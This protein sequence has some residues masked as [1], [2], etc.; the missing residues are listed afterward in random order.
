MCSFS[1]QEGSNDYPFRININ[2]AFGRRFS[3]TYTDCLPS[4][5]CRRLHHFSVYWLRPV[6]VPLVVAFFVVS[7]ITPVLSVLEKRLGVTRIVAAGLTFL[8][9]VVVL[10]LFGCSI[11]VSM[12]DLSTNAQAYRNRVRHLVNRVESYL[13]ARLSFSDSIKPPARTSPTSVSSENTSAIRPDS[14]ATSTSQSTENTDGDPQSDAVQSQMQNEEDKISKSQSSLLM[15]D[16]D[17]DGNKF[18]VAD[19][20]PSD[21]A[22]QFVDQMVRDGITTLSQVFISLV[23]TSIVVDLCLLF[24]D[25]D[26]VHQPFANTQRG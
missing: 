11:W 25:R 8:F 23:S 1:N 19:S 5:A 22:S 18:A 4:C 20:K 10:I 3:N 12:I 15:A 21:K 16:D 26:T 14:D 7:G 2:H 17:I 6:L 13:P 24:V 9:G